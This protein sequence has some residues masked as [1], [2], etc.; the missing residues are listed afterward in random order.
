MK[1]IQASRNADRLT[2][3]CISRI[4]SPDFARPPLGQQILS[5]IRSAKGKGGAVC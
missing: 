3:I 4:H 1:T 5:Y 2:Q